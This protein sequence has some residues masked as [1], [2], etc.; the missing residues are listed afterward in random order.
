MGNGVSKNELEKK[1]VVII[2]GGYGGM[3]AAA[4]CLSLGIPFTLIDPKEFFHHNVGALRGLVY[5]DE[6]MKQTVIGY[7]KTF[8]DKFLQGKVSNVD[9]ENKKVFLEGSDKAIEY[10]DVIFAVGSDGPF[11]GRPQST[12]MEAV[13]EEYRAVSKEIEK[14]NDIVIIGGGPTGVEIAGEIAEKYKTK[15][16]AIIQ[17]NDILGGQELTPKFQSTLKEG[18]ENINVEL[19]LGERVS[20][21]E[22]LSFGICKKQTVNTSKGNNIESDLVLKATGL[23]PNTSMTRKLFDPSKFDENNRLKVNDYLQIEDLD[24]VYAIGDCCDKTAGAGAAMAGDHGKLVASNLIREIKGQSLTVYAHRFEGV[25]VPIGPY[26]G[27]GVFNGWN[28]PA[29]V[30][31]MLK[32][33]QLFTPKYWGIM[34]QT[35]P[36]G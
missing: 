19:H 6:W 20:N 27:A 24:G 11:P 3:E 23:R 36:Q 7:K 30:V 18:L 35:Q 13:I 14:A 1:H 9:F 21:L 34:G 12:K 29:F 25:L 10:T 26:G 16:I 31:S 15:K 8:G 4:E 22:E 33:R 17:S 2:G 5:H 32:G 28:T